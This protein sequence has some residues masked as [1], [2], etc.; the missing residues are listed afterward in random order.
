M[1]EGAVQS[2]SVSQV[3]KTRESIALSG[4][5]S[6]KQEKV[7]NGVTEP[8]TLVEAAPVICHKPVES[9]GATCSLA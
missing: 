3:D 7:N 4:A 1:C 9:S 2:A 8:A 5:S 6:P